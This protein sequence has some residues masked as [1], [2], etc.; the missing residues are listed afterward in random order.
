MVFGL[1]S[2]V[3]LFGL[4]VNGRVK[5]KMNLHQKGIRNAKNCMGNVPNV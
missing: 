5:R 3:R 2:C 1:N 4:V